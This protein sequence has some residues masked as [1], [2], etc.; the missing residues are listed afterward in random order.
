MNNNKDKQPLVSVLMPVYNARAYVS[1]AIES[2]LNQTYSNFELIIVDDASTDGSWEIISE[3]KKKHPFTIR[4]KRLR[5]NRNGGGDVAGNIAFSEARGEYVARMDADDI[6]YPNRLE[7]QVNYMQKHPSCMVLGSQAVVID[8]N[9][10][11]VGKKVVAKS[12]GKI[13]KEY[14]EFH[15][16]I[17]PTL[18]IRRAMVKGNNLYDL[19]WQTNN[20]YLTFFK[21]LTMGKRFKNL[22]EPVLYYRIHGKN[23]SLSG[24]KKKFIN[25]LKTRWVAVTEFGY[26]PSVKSIG[27][28]LM[29]L[30]A[31]VVLPEK[32][33]YQIYLLTKKIVTPIEFVQ[34]LIPF[35]WLRLQSST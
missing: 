35:E 32:I 14:F 18:M 25:S 7:K 1:D 21:Y 11:V 2:I 10:R 17:H 30:V 9:G 23:D 34:N 28:L 29:Q 24:I 6:S 4:T 26:K 8:E 33:L 3:Y 16:M 20:D 15:P 22:N 31:F 5:K 27:T 13:Y 12:H 19:R